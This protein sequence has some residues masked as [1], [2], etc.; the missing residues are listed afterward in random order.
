MNKKNNKCPK[1]G[2]S[3]I[4]Y[5]IKKKKLV[6]NYCHEEFEEKK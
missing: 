6:C 5:D 4:E 2:S 1:C 3:D